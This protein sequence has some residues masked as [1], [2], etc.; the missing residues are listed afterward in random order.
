MNLRRTVVSIL[1]A[2]L[3]PSTAL[4]QAP[5]RD[6]FARGQ[7]SLEAGDAAAARAA[8]E[9]AAAASRGWLL[10]RLELAELAVQ[11]RERLAEERAALLEAAG[12]DSDVP[13]VHRLLAE[14]AELQ[15]DDAAAAESWGAAIERMPYD[16]DL[17]QRRA[18]VL[19]RLGRFG[20]A[21]TDWERVVRARPDEPHLRAQLADALEQVGRHEDARTHLD[22]AIRLLPGREAPVRRLA[23]FLE[24][25]GEKREAAALHAQA[26]RLRARPQQQQRNLRPLLPSKR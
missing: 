5:G 23:R 15:G 19:F 7:A 6:A 3:L 4:A 18:A 14:L 11:R 26:D 22:A 12:A 1:A 10:P 13:R 21:A 16:H 8:F 9:E 2:T 20:E 24:R 25:R 17:K